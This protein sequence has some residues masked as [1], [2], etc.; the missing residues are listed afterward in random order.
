MVRTAR[1]LRL[2]AVCL[3]LATSIAACGAPEKNRTRETDHEDAAVA[4]A[5]L[6][7]PDGGTTT[8]DE[9]VG[10]VMV[11]AY[12]DDDSGWIDSPEEVRMISCDTWQALHRGIVT[13]G[14]HIGLRT[15]Y[16]F[17]EGFYWVG[18]AIG[19]NEV[20]RYEADGAMAACGVQP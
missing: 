5:I 18:D 14:H 20:V 16:G 2:L 11:E 1:L 9:A 19:F 17:Q 15:T 3:A 6:A 13:G 7:I 4:A 8:W 12:D 10:V